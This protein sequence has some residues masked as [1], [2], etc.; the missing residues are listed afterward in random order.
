MPTFHFSS[1]GDITNFPRNTESSIKGKTEIALSVH[2][3][4]QKKMIHIG[5]KSAWYVQLLA[6]QISPTQESTSQVGS[7]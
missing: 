6:S 4:M 3:D 5:P 1:N 7:S 2:T